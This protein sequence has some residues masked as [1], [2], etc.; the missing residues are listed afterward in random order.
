MS[1]YVIRDSKGAPYATEASCF[2]AACQKLELNP[3]ECTGE[4]L[5]EDA[6]NLETAF[7]DCT[8][9]RK[10]RS[11]AIPADMDDKK[12]TEKLVTQM[13]TD[14]IPQLKKESK[15]KMPELKINLKNI[16]KFKT[17]T[18]TKDTKDED[19]N[20]IRQIVSKVS[21]EVEGVADC[22]MI[23]HAL[24]N[25]VEVDVVVGSHQALMDVDMVTGEIKS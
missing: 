8:P 15:R 14:T 2:D 16:Q 3:F 23:H 6:V 20:D 4:I 9:K 7:V 25:D 22:A 5:K 24:A 10:E 13:L 12:S 18:E 1:R 17:T 11:A 19:G 21:F